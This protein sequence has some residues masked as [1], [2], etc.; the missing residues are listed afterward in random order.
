VIELL[1]VLVGSKA[2]G[3]A[4]ED[5][6]T[7]VRIVFA[8]TTRELLSVDGRGNCPQKDTVWA[9]KAKDSGEDHDI[10]GW[11]VAQFVKLALNC[12]PTVLEVLWAPDYRQPHYMGTKLRRIRSAFLSRDR[13]LESFRGYAA[14]QAK[15]MF[16]EP[17]AGIWTVRNWKFAEAYLRA[18][19]Q[20]VEL[21]A[22]GELPVDFTNPL[23][24]NIMGTFQ[25]IRRGEV[26][27]AQVIEAA[28]SMERSMLG[29]YTSS[30]LPGEADLV[31]IND[32]LTEMRFAL[33]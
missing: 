32:Y 10:T 5:S 15:K 23:H 18:L 22:T 29:V 7:D 28:D 3:T 20:G 6:D 13:I 24:V 26:T 21:L 17:G 4:A 19:Y 11:E 8:H 16:F 2:Y 12:N 33:W 31:K 1:Q 25:M 9:E 27:K 30:K 14:N